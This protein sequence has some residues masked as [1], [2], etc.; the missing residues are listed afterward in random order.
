MKDF[1]LFSKTLLQY[2]E[3]LL[4][5]LFMTI[6]MIG[7]LVLGIREEQLYLKQIYFVCSAWGLAV[8]VFIFSYA[9]RH[10][11]ELIK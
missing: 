6:L 7:S 11:D 4:S 3:H 5:V 2:K 9:Y 10:K 8:V 1:L